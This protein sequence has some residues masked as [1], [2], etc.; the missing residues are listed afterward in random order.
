MR[1]QRR[2]ALITSVAAMVAGTDAL[3]IGPM[4]MQPGHL[5]TIAAYDAAE[6]YPNLRVVQRSRLPG[7]VACDATDLDPNSPEYRQREAEKRLALAAERR[8]KAEVRHRVRTFRRAYL[9]LFVPTFQCWQ[10]LDLSAEEIEALTEAS[11]DLGPVHQSK[12]E[13][14]PKALISPFGGAEDFYGQLRN[15]RQDPVPEVWDNLRAKWPV[16]AERSDDDL[17][18]ALQPIKDIKVDRR[19]LK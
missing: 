16:L 9:C 2:R 18:A 7:I 8:A 1:T 19:S 15:P 5:S 3:R 14:C 17:L 11:K 4:F 10:E 13:P 12:E 6:F